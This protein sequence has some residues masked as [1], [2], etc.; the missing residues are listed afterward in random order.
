MVSCQY[1][2]RSRRGSERMDG[3][4]RTPGSPKHNTKVPSGANYVVCPF[5]LGSA[6]MVISAGPHAGTK[7]PRALGNTAVAFQVTTTEY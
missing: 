5:G 2:V 1:Q 6:E 7:L 4:F 3:V